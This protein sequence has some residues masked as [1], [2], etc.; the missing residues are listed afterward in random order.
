MVVLDNYSRFPIFERITNIKPQITVIS[1]LDTIFSI[2]GISSSCRT[3]NGAPFHGHKFAEFAKYM[4]FE[5]R[6]IS[7]RHPMGN[8]Q[9]ERRFM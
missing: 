3:D 6:K 2:W 5:H 8:S 4:R 1:R 7:P 9:V